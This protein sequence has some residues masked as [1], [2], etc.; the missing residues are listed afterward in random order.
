VSRWPLSIVR[1]LAARD[2]VA[3]RQALAAA[4]ADQ[5]W[6][7]SERDAAA[8]ALRA[9]RSAADESA[10]RAAV[11]GS[12]ASLRGAALHLARLGAERPRLALALRAAED[13]LARAER[14]V[15]ARRE[16]LVAARRRIAIF[17]RLRDAWRSARA[18]ALDAAA[19]D[20]ADDAVSARCR[21]AR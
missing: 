17:E 6:R 16:G 8:D 13:A 12:S 18:R 10:R 11:P 20:S 14:E 7:R 4:L 5:G 1:D 19:D 15:E 2:E 9:H 3:A 21:A